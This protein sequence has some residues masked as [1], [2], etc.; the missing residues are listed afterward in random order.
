MNWPEYPC[1]RIA[2]S[3]IVGVALGNLIVIPIYLGL[4]ILFIFVI[5]LIWT[6]R[7]SGLG[8]HTIRVLNIIIILSGTISGLT[9][10]SLQ[11]SIN[12]HY[13][14]SHYK[15]SDADTLVGVIL[16]NIKKK[17]S[18]K[19]TVGIKT[20]NGRNVR[21]KLLVYFPKGDSI[22]HLSAG[23]VIGFK[24]IIYGS[25]KNSNPQA[26][27]Y[28][29]YLR[30]R[31][32]TYQSY[33]KKDMY[34]LLSDGELPW[35]FQYT[36]DLRERALDIFRNKLD[37]KE[38]LATASAMVLGY[39]D[40]IS[41]ELYNAYATTGS[42]HVLAVSGLHV[43]IICWIF[44]VLFKRIKSEL[45]PVR[46]FKA[47][48]LLLLVWFYAI[49]TGAAPAVIRASVMFSIIIIGKYWFDH[50]NIYN[51]LALSA[52]LLL[53]YDPFLLYQASFQFS[54]LA[55]LG[56]VFFHKIFYLLWE[57]K[58]VIVD[59][60]WNLLVVAFA[61][62]ILV[63]PVTVYYFH[64][65]PLYFLL[66]GLFSVIL[67]FI[68]LI[69][70]ILVLL[71]SWVPVF[72]GI[73]VSFL[74]IALNTFIVIVYFIQDLPYSNIA[75]I[76]FSVQ[77]TLLIY[78]ILLS[79]MF[80]HYNQKKI[81]AL[82]FVGVA[83]LGLIIN[84]SIYDKE[85]ESQYMLTLYDVNGATI[86]DV[87]KG[88]VC[89]NLVSDDIDTAD[90]QFITENYRMSRAIKSI[91]NL[92]EHY[93]KIGKYKNGLFQYKDRLIYLP[94]IAENSKSIPQYSD[95]LMVTN[96]LNV[97]PSKLL[98]CHDTELIVVDKS[99]D[100]KKRKA[101]LNYAENYGIAYHDIRNH[102]VFMK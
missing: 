52:L 97:W 13:H 101:W 25:R 8:D 65:F 1:L 24:S 16:E 22:G 87:F 88:K 93:K 28:K 67:A 2:I 76:W 37:T 40:H 27:D 50:Q 26:F 55:L 44:I 45:L 62:Q 21:G 4:V 73:L 100:W 68:I 58:N 98:K 23:S 84:K 47:F 79:L 85:I 7:I 82:Y 43:G 72:G 69:S 17:N 71:L 61:A 46:I 54:Y 39:R 80:L 48:T 15:T 51:T 56:I 38:Q 83:I 78:V 33:L 49:L 29:S 30:N 90:I 86:L 32:V 59:Y 102:G 20:I 66:S 63:F 99:I 57:P 89:Y 10:T 18:L 36:H 92:K 41:E 77:T 35:L 42:V 31:G 96:N 70:G 6:D 53:L 5:V 64:K 11:K 9:R 12:D 95:V 14:Y 74:K 60:V 81:K 94:A 75:G 3:F 19:T 34:T 91:E